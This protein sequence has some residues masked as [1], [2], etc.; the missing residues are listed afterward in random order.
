M[1]KQQTVSKKF[2][3]KGI[4]KMFGGANVLISKANNDEVNKHKRYIMA[5]SGV[6][7]ISP[8]AV[9]ILGGLPYIQNLGKKQLLHKFFK[10]S[11][12]KYNWVKR[13]ENDDDKAICEVKI[14][15]GNKDLTDWIVG[16]CSPASLK[17]GTLKGYQ[18]HI[19][20]TR[21]QNRAVQE[22]CGELI[23]EKLLKG[24]NSL[25]DKGN[26]SEKEASVMLNASLA[27]AEEV[28]EDKTTSEKIED[29]KP[30]DDAAKLKAIIQ[31]IASI[32]NIK[33]AEEKL[34]ILN[35]NNDI[36]K[37]IKMTAK[38]LLEVKIKMFKK[39]NE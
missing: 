2:K 3:N 36:S 29:L 31:G 18:N 39:R 7:E 23:H 21:A 12:F 15:E 35:S 6:L 14:V 11:S 34:K 28:I 22:L 1:K 20:Q 17:M 19:A 32:N 38:N 25:V 16:E 37:D 24:I 30:S 5:V 10:K 13:S 4:E 27:S 9:T 26:V 8:L 33:D